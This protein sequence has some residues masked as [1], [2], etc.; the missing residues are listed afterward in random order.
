MSTPPSSKQKIRP[1]VNSSDF[2]PT[3]HTRF[4]TSLCFVS[5]AG[6]RHCQAHPETRECQR[7]GS[8]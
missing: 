5:L 4:L 2:P 7:V 6:G 1:P 3:T 8:N